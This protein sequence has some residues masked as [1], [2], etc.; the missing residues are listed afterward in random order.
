MNYCVPINRKAL[1]DLVYPLSLIAVFLVPLELPLAERNGIVKFMIGDLSEFVYVG[2]VV[3]FTSLLLLISMGWKRIVEQ[4]RC[5]SFWGLST[6]YLGVGM[7]GVLVTAFLQNGNTKFSV[8]QLL[9][10]YLAP[11]SCCGAILACEPAK[12]RTAW[13]AFYAGWIFFF[14]WS[15]TLL[16]RSW[17]SAI[18]FD[19]IFASATLG[20]RLFLW[21]FTFSQDWNLYALF[22]GNANKT[23]NNIL[24]FFLLSARLLEVERDRSFLYRIAFKLFGYLGILTLVMLFSRAALFLLPLVIYKSGFWRSIHKPVRALALTG[25]VLTVFIWGDRMRRRSTIC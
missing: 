10:G 21:R 13:L 22:V 24:I 7:L 18:A 19:P 3:L 23:S 20:Q 9:L 25:I 4:V 16:P 14:L 5:N 1:E 12:R 2:H 8:Q 6:L 15:L 11:I 17:H